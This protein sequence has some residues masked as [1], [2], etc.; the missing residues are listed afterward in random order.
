M[1]RSQYYPTI[2]PRFIEETAIENNVY[3]LLHLTTVYLTKGRRPVIID[4]LFQTLLKDMMTTTS[5][6]SIERT[7]LLARTPEL[8]I[9]LPVQKMALGLSKAFDLSPAAAVSIVWPNWA[10]SNYQEHLQRFVDFAV[11]IMNVAPSS[12]DEETA[13]KGIH[14][15]EKFCR[16]FHFPATLEDAGIFLTDT[17]MSELIKSCLPHEKMNEKAAIYLILKNSQ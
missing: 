17:E 4:K 11:N 13:L 6:Y 14:A 1:E 2:S 7:G 5:H 10:R 12:S 8:F 3:F 15:M 9:Q 16:G